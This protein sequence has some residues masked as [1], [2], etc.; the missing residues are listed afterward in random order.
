MSFRSGCA[1]WSAGAPC[2]MVYP[3]FGHVSLTFFD[4]ES[5]QR[6]DNSDGRVGLSIPRSCMVDFDGL[7]EGGGQ[8]W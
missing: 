8:R 4:Q 6:T 1:G 3:F 5:F 2:G 7:V